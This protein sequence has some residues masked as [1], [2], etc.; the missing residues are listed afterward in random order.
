MVNTFAW[1]PVHRVMSKITRVSKTLF[2]FGAFVAPLAFAEAAVAAPAATTVNFSVTVG[3]ISAGKQN[4]VELET[5]GGS[6]I[7]SCLDTSPTAIT[8]TCSIPV[9]VNTGVLAIAQPAPGEAW[10]LFVGGGCLNAPGPVCHVQVGTKNVN[11]FAGFGPAVHGPSISALTY[12]PGTSGLPIALGQSPTL[13]P[14]NF[15]KY[16]ITINGSG[17]PANAPA[18]LSDNGQLVATGTSDPN[19]VVSFTYYPQSEPQLYRKLV[20]GV[21]GQTASTD[22]YNSLIYYELQS[23]SNPGTIMFKI[24]ETDMDST[25]DNYVQFNNNAPAPVTFGDG[26]AAQGYAQIIT[27]TYACTPGSTNTLTIYGTRGKGTTG[28]FKYGVPI[29]IGC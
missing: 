22:V 12:K 10:K 18:T 13:S 3:D 11:L 15:D 16:P 25:V 17:F 27:P 7:G 26:S 8:Q 23:T 29:S 14:Y 28:V 1:Q 4:A 6:F 21:S 20:V 19:G 24:N 2:I 5:T 9:P